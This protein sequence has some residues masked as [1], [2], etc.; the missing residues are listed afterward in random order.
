MALIQAEIKIN[1]GINALLVDGIITGNPMIMSFNIN[2]IPTRIRK[3][4]V[5]SKSKTST[6]ATGRHLHKGG[7]FDIVVKFEIICNLATY[8]QIDMD[9]LELPEGVDIIMQ[10]EEGFV[11]EGDFPG[12]KKSRNNANMNFMQFRVPKRIKNQILQTTS[13]LEVEAI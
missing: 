3:S 13:T 10:L 1:Q 8:I 4:P 5:V 11:V 12:T 9:K 2:C 6:I 7:V